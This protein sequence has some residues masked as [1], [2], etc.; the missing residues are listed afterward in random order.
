MDAFPLPNGYEVAKTGDHAATVSIEPLSPGYGTTIG[1]ALRRVL[2][3]SLSGT[4]VTSVKVPRVEH[5]F[6][7]IEG[8]KEDMVEVILNIKQLHVAMTTDE[9]QV[10]KLSVKKEG[11]VTAAAFEETSEA[12]VMNK[13]LVIAHVTDS[14]IGFEMEIVVERGRGYLQVEQRKDEELGVGVI[15]IDA[16]FSPVV[17]VGYET[18]NM[19]VGQRTDFD[20]LSLHIETD[21]SVTPENAFE[22]AA[23]LLMDH[24]A[25]L[26]GDAQS[27]SK[28]MAQLQ[29]EEAPQEEVV[30]EPVTALG[31]STRTANALSRAGI[32]RMSQLVK[33]SDEDLLA[34]EG[35]GQT[36]LQEVRAK[37][38][39][40]IEM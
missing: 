5:E 28:P 36:A 9:P 4:A 7:A 12:K 38:G 39:P 22:Q 2:L 6:S 14:K 35:F 1:N 29:A 30:D 16:L 19:R 23:R 34:L 17:K 18:E 27:E 31:F 15:A 8:V 20:R 21:G 24:F 11:P 3:S 33:M 13:D 26:M 10:L 37:I 40:A 32:E 25:I